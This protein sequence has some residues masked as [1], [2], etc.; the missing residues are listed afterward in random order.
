MGGAKYPEQ[1]FNKTAARSAVTTLILAAIALLLPTLFHRTA[2][3]AWTPQL[4][5]IGCRSAIA[6]VLIS[7]LRRLTLAFSLVTHKKLF[8]GNS[9]HAERSPDDEIETA[10][11]SRVRRR[12]N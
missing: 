1:R 3:D 10:A 12:T 8:A 5:Q 7:H 11:Q 9:S 6:V 2:G 4:E